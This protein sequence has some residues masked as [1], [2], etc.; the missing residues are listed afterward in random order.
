MH[1]MLRLSLALA[2]A[3][4]ALACNKGKKSTT[5]MTASSD[6]TPKPTGTRAAS[7][8]GTATVTPVVGPGDPAAPD[9][10]AIY[11]EFDS[12]SLSGEARD[13]LERLG[14]WL[15]KHPARVVIE[16]HADDRG[17]TE[18]NIALGQ[19]RAQVIAEYLVRLGVEATHLETIS[20]GEERPAAEGEGESAWAQN[21][22]GELHPR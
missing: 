2:I 10:G 14:A 4:G 5:V 15:A 19:R 17:T 12:T 18:Y 11:F 1:L 20:Y 7:A 22:R 8:P 3:G 9:F 13:V 6:G 16:G 21:R